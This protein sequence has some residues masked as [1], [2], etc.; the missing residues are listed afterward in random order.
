M[1]LKGLHIGG[2]Y[3]V[4]MRFL[5]LIHLGRQTSLHPE[6]TLIHLGRQK[7]ILPFYGEMVQAH[8]EV[9][10]HSR[11]RHS[12]AVFGIFLHPH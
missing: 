12:L 5:D 9:E 4:E 3:F 1:I 6:K 7:N 2:F 11:D 8:I 10:L